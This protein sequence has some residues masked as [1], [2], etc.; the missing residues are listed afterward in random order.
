MGVPLHS[1]TVHP[2]RGGAGLFLSGLTYAHYSRSPH[3]AMSERDFDSAGSRCNARLSPRAPSAFMNTL[4]RCRADVRTGSRYENRSTWDTR[5]SRVQR[6]PV[7][8]NC[9]S[10]RQKPNL[11]GEEFAL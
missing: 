8:A 3:L 4:C 2:A 7:R 6:E 11:P 9:L 10:N 5:C 1:A